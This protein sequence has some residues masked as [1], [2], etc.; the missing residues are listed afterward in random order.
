[1]FLLE[2]FRGWDLHAAWDDVA[3]G[4]KHYHDLERVALIG[5]PSWAAWMAKLS[6]PFTAAEVK[7]FPVDEVDVAWDWLLDKK[8]QSA[9]CR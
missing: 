4:V 7:H 2:D 9:C 8:S 3:F 5:K 1:M 6:R